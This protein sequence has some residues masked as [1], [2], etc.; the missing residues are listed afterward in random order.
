MERDNALDTDLRGTP[1]PPAI[2]ATPIAAIGR[3][4]THVEDMKR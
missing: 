4:R 2:S 3:D 1:T